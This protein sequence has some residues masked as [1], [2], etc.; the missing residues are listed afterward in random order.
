MGDGTIRK[1][2]CDFVQALHSNFSSIFTRFRDIVAFVLQHTMHFF[3][4]ASSLLKMSPCY[5]GNRLGGCLWA[6]KSE[7]VGLMLCNQFPRF[8]TYVVLIH[9]ATTQTV[10]QTDGRDGRHAIAIQRFALVV[11]RAVKMVNSFKLNGIMKTL[12]YTVTYRIVRLCCRRSSP[13]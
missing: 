7:G 5:S 13:I 8:P 6:T 2:V 1:N 10:M 12:C 9:L 3:P 11:H 4:P